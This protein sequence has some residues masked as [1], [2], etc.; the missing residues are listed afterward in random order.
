M[1]ASPNSYGTNDLWIAI[2][3]TNDPVSSAS[4]A[5]LTLH[6]TATNVW[7]TTNIW[8]LL[9]KP[10]LRSPFW[11]PGQ[12]VVNDAG[13]GQITFDPLLIGDT[14]AMFFRGV[15]GDTVVE[16]TPD[17]SFP[18]AIEP[19]AAS[20]YDG[21]I[22]KF[23]VGIN[24]ELSYDLTVVYRISGT[25]SNGV[26]YTTLSGSVIVPAGATQTNITVRPLEDPCVDFDETVTLSL[27]LTNGY[28]IYP[29]FSSATITISDYLP[30]AFCPVVTNLNG[31]VGIDYYAPSNWLVASL[32]YANG[33]PN[34]FIRVDTN[35]FPTNWSGVHGLTEEVKV[36]TVKKTASGFTNGEMYF[37]TGVNGVIGKLSADGSVSNLN[38]GVLTTNQ[39]TT[40][41]LLR[42]G[43]YVDRSGSFGGDLIAVTGNRPDEGGGV[44]RINSS[45]NATPLANITNTHLEGV[46]TLTYD[47]QKW[48]PW[49]G[50]IITGAESLSPPLVY[51]VDTNG[52]VTSFALG[53]E[54]ED[55]DLIPTNQ[56]LYCVDETFGQIVKF[57]GTLL[58]NYWSDLLIT[59]S[60]D[61]AGDFGALF[62][63]HWDSTNSTFVT[64][65]IPYTSQ[66]EHVTFAPMNIPCL[67]P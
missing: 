55:F 12:Y 42:G 40:E 14:P 56:D 6:G 52:T 53:I 48:G 33:E 47:V 10:D 46:I 27:V 11:T 7:T 50:K 64:R 25:A 26:D 41:S 43:L 4:E 29:Q 20:G 21:Q 62:I 54:P 37:G 60:G 57:P 58:T 24:P 13:A 30:N 19:N 65:R 36:A 59:Q 18:H 31:P 34:S 17:S 3:L 44:W 67:T 45:G 23:D 35:G 61:G 49:A 1:D 66:F 5:L 9:S 28:L 39:M 38:W 22:A 63:V 51:A 16:I 15:G 32:N 8:Q 2:D